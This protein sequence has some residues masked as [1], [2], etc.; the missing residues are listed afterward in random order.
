MEA[1]LTV[2]GITRQAFYSGA[3]VGNHVTKALH[4]RL[5]IISKLVEYCT[6]KDT[7]MTAEQLNFQVQ[8]H[9]LACKH[10]RLWDQLAQLHTL[11]M[12]AALLTPAEIETVCR[13]GPQLAANWRRSNAHRQRVT[14]KMHQLEAHVG[15]F[16]RHFRTAGLLA[17]HG[18]ESVHRLMHSNNNSSMRVAKT[19][20]RLRVLHSRNMLQTSTR[21]VELFKSRKEAKKRGPR[22]PRKKKNNE[23]LDT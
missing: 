6:V 5:D 8:I 3:F 13:L 2:L 16:V 9:K 4:K 15:Q 22:G 21:L 19:Q 18:I 12:R 7:A 23:S 1:Y 10:L 20:L 14:L 17:E 11:L